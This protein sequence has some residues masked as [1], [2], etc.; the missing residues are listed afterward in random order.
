MAVTNYNSNK[1][2]ENLFIKSYNNCEINYN[3][4][5]NNNKKYKKIVII[6]LKDLMI[7]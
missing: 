7:Y 2:K 4:K 5:Y 1:S 3:N 6:M